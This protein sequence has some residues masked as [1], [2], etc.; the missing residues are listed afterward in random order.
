MLQNSN[1][2]L[3]PQQSPSIDPT[4]PRVHQ[5]QGGHCGLQEVQ[6]DRTP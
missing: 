4:A 2:L 3:G 1:Y 6:E 5:D